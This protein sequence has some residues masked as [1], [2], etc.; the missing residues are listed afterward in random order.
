MTTKRMIHVSVG[1]TKL[2]LRVSAT[3]P[4]EEEV[5][6]LAAKLIDKRLKDYQIKFSDKQKNDILAMVLLEFAKEMIL[7]KQKK[8]VLI[9]QDAIE[10]IHQKLQLLNH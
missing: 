9:D 3:D 5:V 7:E 4:T 1:D 2:P 8:E 6:R 10:R